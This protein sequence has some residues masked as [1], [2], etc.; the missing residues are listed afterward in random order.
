LTAISDQLHQW[1]APQLAIP[2]S[3]LRLASRAEIVYSGAME[4]ILV[5]SA[6]GTPVDHDDNLH[7][8]GLERHVEQQL[9]AGID[10]LL[11]GG[12]MG[13]MPLLKES[14]YVELVRASVSHWRGRGELLVGVGDTSYART[15]AKLRSVSEF[16]ID[17]VVAT[18]PYFLKFTQPELLAYFRSLADA[19]P[20]P[21]YLYDLPQRTGNGLDLGTML[22]LAEHSNIAG[23][24]CSG[25]LSTIRQLRDEVSRADFRIIVAHVTLFD[26]LLRAGFTYQL[27]GVFAIVP[28]LA[29]RVA[30]AA[31]REDWK[32]AGEGMVLMN[33]LLKML[34]KYGVF[35]SMTAILNWRGI[36]GNFAPSPC[37][38]LSEQSLK[39]LLAEEALRRAFAE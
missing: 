20:K 27:D 1:E 9:D 11:V 28:K 22:Q 15:L 13:A 30:D 24:K 39:G 18:A 32:S 26:V 33:E 19:S 34:V 31:K 16:D 38:P 23:I 25:D 36:P 6:I 7:A 8:E 21:L 10:G 14:T 4:N 2:G 17:G 12:T 35:P 37:L 5:Y 29:M 3:E